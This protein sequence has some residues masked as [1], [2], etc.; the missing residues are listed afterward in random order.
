MVVPESMG[1]EKVCAMSCSLPHNTAGVV[2]YASQFA[3]ITH[4]KIYAGD[5]YAILKI[6]IIGGVSHLCAKIY[7]GF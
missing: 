5:I 1:H 7:I 6:L 3:K 4:H 2:I